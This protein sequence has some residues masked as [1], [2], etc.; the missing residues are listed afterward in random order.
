MKRLVSWMM[1]RKETKKGFTLVELLVVIAIL[2]V[3]ATVSVVGYTSFTDDARASNDLQE[4]TQYRAIIEGKLMDGSEVVTVGGKEY[5]VTYNERREMKCMESDVA[6]SNVTTI[7]T[8]LETILSVD[9]NPLAD[10]ASFSVSM[11]GELVDKIYYSHNVEAKVYWD[12]P[13][14]TI[15]K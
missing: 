15:V 10:D 6:V 13:M 14:G 4:L 5:E 2:A 7:A 11:A 12:V 9:E 8:V 1:K 3:L